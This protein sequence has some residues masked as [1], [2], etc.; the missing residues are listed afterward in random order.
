MFQMVSN[1]FFLILDQISQLGQSVLALKY[2]L[3]TDISPSLLFPSSLHRICWIP[4]LPTLPNCI[5][6]PL[7]CLIMLIL[8]SKHFGGSPL[9]SAQRSNLLIW[10]EVHWPPS[11]LDQ[12]TFFY[13]PMIFNSDAFDYAVSSAWNKAQWNLQ[14]INSLFS[15]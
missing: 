13:C 3:Y 4:Q 5:Y 12:H 1:V 9:S 8:Y 7:H 10:L 11:S 15:C 14:I 6:C 2:A